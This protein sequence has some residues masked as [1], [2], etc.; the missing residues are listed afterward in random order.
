M[1]SN[2]QWKKLTKLW[3]SFIDYD[4]LEWQRTLQD[5]DKAPDIAYENVLSSFDKD[6]CVKGLIVT[7]KDLVVTLKFR[8]MTSSLGSLVFGM[9]DFVLAI[10]VVSICAQKV[11]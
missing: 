1:L 11:Q 3:D 5:L 8:P 4:T 6:W 7:H 2:G 9:F 10:E